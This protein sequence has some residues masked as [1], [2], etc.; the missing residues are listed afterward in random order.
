MEQENEYKNNK[1]TEQTIDMIRSTL[2]KMQLGVNSIRD[3][4]KVTN[5]ILLRA[6]ER[7]EQNGK[8]E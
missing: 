2:W 3:E 1:S 4:M 5:E 7:F 6:V 8:K